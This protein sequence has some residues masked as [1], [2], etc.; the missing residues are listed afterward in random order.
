MADEKM[1][2]I[3][4]AQLQQIM[5]QTSAATVQLAFKQ[6]AATLEQPNL[7]QVNN[8]AAKPVVEETLKQVAAL[9]RKA[10]TTFTVEV[11]KNP[12]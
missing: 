3:S 6:F 12:S 7:A 1:I 11:K 5:Q 4:E 8:P 9:A 2:T 10:A